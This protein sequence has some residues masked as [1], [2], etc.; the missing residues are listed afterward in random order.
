MIRDEV[1][2]PDAF[3]FCGL[4][5]LGVLAKLFLLAKAIYFEFW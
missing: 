1:S 3:R 5:S 2:I 4:L